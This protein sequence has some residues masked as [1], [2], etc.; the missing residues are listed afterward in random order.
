MI[1]KSMRSP[2]VTALVMT[3]KV[4]HDNVDEVS[5]SVTIVV[6]E[7]NLSLFVVP[8]I[9]LEVFFRFLL[10]NPLNYLHQRFFHFYDV[11]IKLL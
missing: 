3:L 10:F 11:R 6:N 2:C 8:N 1:L 5:L 4:G 7:H 9:F